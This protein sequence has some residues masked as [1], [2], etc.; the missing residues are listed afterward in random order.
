M[1]S[2]GRKES[3][4][5][6]LAIDVPHRS[7]GVS[8]RR[9]ERAQ[10]PEYAFAEIERAAPGD[11]DADDWHTVGGRQRGVDAEFVRATA[12]EVVVKREYVPGLRKWKHDAAAQHGP[13]VVQAVFERRD[14]T[15]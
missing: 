2:S 11:A 14:D 3:V 8:E 13:H 15:N 9:L 1:S 4:A 5:G 10:R 6:A 7:D 12:R